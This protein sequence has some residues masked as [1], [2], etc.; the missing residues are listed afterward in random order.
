MVQ[1]FK[2][3]NQLGS[4]TVFPTRLLNGKKKREGV[5]KSESG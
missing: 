2:S 4:I 5:N 1:S 3:Y